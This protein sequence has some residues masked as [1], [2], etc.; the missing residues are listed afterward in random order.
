M[1]SKRFY[2]TTLAQDPS[3]LAPTIS[4]GLSDRTPKDKVA[5][6]VR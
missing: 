3:D 4:L 2:E 6:D 1:D 5:E